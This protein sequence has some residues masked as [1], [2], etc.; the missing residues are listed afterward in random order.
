MVR[1]WSL[2]PGQPEAET[3]LCR[4]LGVSRLLAHLLAGRGLA[5][6]AAASS[7]LGARLSEHLRSPMLFKNMGAAADRVIAALRGGERIGIYGDYD[8]DGISGSAIL[9][10][11][12]RALGH[13]PALYI[14]HR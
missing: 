12:L 2:V 11:F 5:T 4:E 1:R 13:E 14:P 7:F 3:A 9:V 6:P 10:R 8:V